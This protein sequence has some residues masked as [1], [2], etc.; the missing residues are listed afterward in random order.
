MC[1]VTKRKCQA[2]KGSLIKQK[3]EQN[4]MSASWSQTQ[5]GGMLFWTWGWGT[6][7]TDPEKWESSMLVFNSSLPPL[8]ETTSEPNLAY[9]NY[10][11]EM[12]CWAGCWPGAC[13]STATCQVGPLGHFI[14][15]RPWETCSSQAEHLGSQSGRLQVFTC[16]QSGKWDSLLLK[17]SGGWQNFWAKFRLF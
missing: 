15:G 13:T 5:G 10:C 12:N 1:S 7:E 14:W 16:A 8:L 6:P 4:G 17:T 3:A 11:K 9:W 2:L